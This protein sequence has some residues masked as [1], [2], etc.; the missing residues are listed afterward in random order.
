MRLERIL[1]DQKAS[2][3]DKSFHHQ[4]VASNLTNEL[5]A[6]NDKITQLTQENK[7]CSEK[8]A[9]AEVSIRDTYYKEKEK[10]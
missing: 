6:L 8:Y 5:L 7:E 2:L 10:L 1:S 4:K 9:Q 3:N